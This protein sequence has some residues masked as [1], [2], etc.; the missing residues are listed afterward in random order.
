ME[1]KPTLRD[2]LASTRVSVS[3]TEFQAAAALDPRQGASWALWGATTGD[4]S[5]FNDSTVAAPR[6]RKDVVLI[7]ANFGLGGDAGAFKT[8]QNFH[9]SNSGGDTKL[10]KALTGTVLEGA[11]L[12]DI[13]KDYATKYANGL[14]AEI[15][16]GRLDVDRYVAA[17]FKAEQEAL[18]IGPDALYIP[19]GGRTREL[20]DLLVELGVIPAEQRVFHREYGGGPLFNGK[21]VLNLN[22][23]SAA[24]NMDEA[25]EALLSQHS[26][27]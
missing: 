23:Y 4:L 20:W 2:Q 3:V 11:F 25:V 22:H 13:V 21:P 17:G 10:R 15:K 24:V 18:D 1:T 16:T 26:L 19:V 14:A 12:T 6:L 9:A 7:G 27:K 8:F 5:V